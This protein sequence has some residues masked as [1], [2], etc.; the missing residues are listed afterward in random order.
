M[1]LERRPASEPNIQIDLDGLAVSAAL[2]I[3]SAPMTTAALRD[4]LPLSGRV[5]HAKWNGP[6]FFIALDDGLLPELPIENAQH[7]VPPGRLVYVADPREVLLTYG[8]VRLSSGPSAYRRECVFGY[9]TSD[10]GAMRD[11]VLA[12]RLSGM[13]LMTLTTEGS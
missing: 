13:G 3:G 7:V 12:M 6:A 2:L 9:V 5:T 10:L 4:A 11:K 8:N 1:V